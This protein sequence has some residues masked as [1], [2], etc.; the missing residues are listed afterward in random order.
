MGWI[1]LLLA[2]SFEVTG[3]TSL[4]QY[5]AKGKWQ[6]LGAMSLSMALSF[7]FLTLALQTISMGT[8]YAVWTGIG[9]MGG[10]LVGM[11]L[12]GESKDWRRILFILMVV[13]S[14]IGLK[15]IS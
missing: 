15:L 6:A 2:G 3:V 9:T 14:V 5:K 13:A 7:L 12:F 8:G 4:N 1:Y 11:L 10:T